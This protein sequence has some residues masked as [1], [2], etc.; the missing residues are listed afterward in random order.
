MASRSDD[1]F[2]R[3]APVLEKLLAQSQ[4]EYSATRWNIERR[5]TP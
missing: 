2:E 4:S 1:D 3:A 5:S